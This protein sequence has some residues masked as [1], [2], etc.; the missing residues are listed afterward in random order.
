VFMPKPS[1]ELTWTIAFP[2]FTNIIPFHENKSY[3]QTYVMQTEH[4]TC[5]VASDSKH[6]D[7]VLIEKLPFHYNG[8]KDI[9]VW[10]IHVCHFSSLD[11]FFHF[12]V[13]QFSNIESKE[14]IILIMDSAST[15]ALSNYEWNLFEEKYTY[16]YN[17][18]LNK[19]LDSL[20]LV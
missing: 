6:A 16:L 17:Y 3:Y 12:F 11:R 18:R 5:F 13:H 10:K 7:Y 19:I 20:F 1:V 14:E 15:E 9:P 4:R 8:Q 2:S